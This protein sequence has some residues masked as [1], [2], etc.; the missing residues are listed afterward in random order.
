MLRVFAYRCLAIISISLGILGIPLPGLPTVPFVLL[1]AWAAG[2]GWPAFEQWLLV[3]P[4]FGPPIVQ[5]R[6]QGAVSRK[7]KWLASIMMLSSIV[8]L[9]L[10]AAPYLLKLLIT[11]MLVLVALW[12]WRRPEPTLNDEVKYGRDT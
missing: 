6:Q 12:L 7:A 1:S 2:K 8:L 11:V 10:S 3:H 4:R 9:Y 5:W